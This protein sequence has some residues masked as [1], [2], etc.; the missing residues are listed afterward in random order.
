[1]N[2]TS[3]VLLYNQNDAMVDEHGIYS[4]IQTPVMPQLDSHD[5]MEF[6]VDSEIECARF[7]HQ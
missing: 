7:V 2:P 6:A 1:M 4:W 5:S 3:W